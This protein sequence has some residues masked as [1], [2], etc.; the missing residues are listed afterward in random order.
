[1]R[2][3]DTNYYRDNI[4]QRARGRGNILL[5][6]NNNNI[7]LSSAIAHPPKEVELRVIA[8]IGIYIAFLGIVVAT[9]FYILMVK[10][11]GNLIKY[12]YISK[13]YWGA[14]LI[15]VILIVGAFT[16]WVIVWTDK[17]SFIIKTAHIVYK[18]KAITYN[19]RERKFYDEIWDIQRGEWFRKKVIYC[20]GVNINAKRPTYRLPLVFLNESEA[21]YL[22]DV[23]HTG[24]YLK[25]ENNI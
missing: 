24:K 20:Y 15:A 18:D 19:G 13:E 16:I 7:H 1:M 23:F 8:N 10:V 3:I 21:K 6:G 17:I 5:N 4:H 2:K 9:L 11:V 14:A 12:D 25:G 22:Y